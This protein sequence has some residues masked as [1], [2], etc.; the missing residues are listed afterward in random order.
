[1]AVVNIVHHEREEHWL[2]NFEEGHL[3]QKALGSWKGVT[4]D[5]IPCDGS[6]EK[7]NIVIMLFFPVSLWFDIHMCQ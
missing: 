6:G 1:M 5:V 3:E 2:L 7:N 4:K